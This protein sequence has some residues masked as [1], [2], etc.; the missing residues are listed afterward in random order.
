MRFAPLFFL[1]SAAIC[2]AGTITDVFGPNTTGDV[3]GPHI[4]FDIQQASVTMAGG[5]TTVTIK[6]DYG[7]T[8]TTSNGLK[9]DPQNAAVTV[10]PG[11]I[12]FFD[13]ST[14]TD[15]SDP[16]AI[17]SDLKYGVAL[18]N[19]NSL[20]PSENHSLFTPGALYQIDGVN[21]GLAT[22]QQALNNPSG[23]T[24]RPTAPVLLTDLSGQATAADISS[25]PV[26]VTQT[27]DG[28]TAGMYTVTVAFQT[29]SSGNFMNLVHNNQI[30]L[31][32][33]SADCGNDFIEGSVNTAAPE[34]AS[35]ALLGGGALLIAGSA[36]SR[37]CR[38]WFKSAGSA[39]A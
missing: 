18:T 2:S 4:D 27:G 10:I 23:V 20:T 34:P 37:R 30:G 21:V 11:D 36:L 7:T 29:S 31:L 32:F 12:F 24:Y 8:E 33:S 35:F 19:Y 9:L 6:T 1:L 26:T 16:S 14:V 17:Q 22:A 38:T 39:K 13:A 5:W 28:T 15:F 25:R 3:I